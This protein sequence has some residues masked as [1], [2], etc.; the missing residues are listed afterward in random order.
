[1]DKEDSSVLD[2]NI[3]TVE[4]EVL[5]GMAELYLGE[6]VHLEDEEVHR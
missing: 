2:S 4:E 1:M 3:K 6:E 5:V